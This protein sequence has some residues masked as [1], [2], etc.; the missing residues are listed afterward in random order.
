MLGAQNS[1][2]V[3]GDA[4]CQ[5]DSFDGFASFAQPPRV[6]DTAA[7]RVGMLGA[8]N[9]DAVSGDAGCQTGGF[10]LFTSL[11]RQLA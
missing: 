6:G 11:P 4:D 9:S 8:Q 3:T 10:G 7:K 5:T 2:A 1:H